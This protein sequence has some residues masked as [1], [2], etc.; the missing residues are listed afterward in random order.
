MQPDPSAAPPPATITQP[1]RKRFKFPQMHPCIRC[2][3]PCRLPLC[4][5]CRLVA[6]PHPCPRCGTTTKRPV[7][8]SMCTP[9]NIKLVSPQPPD[10]LPA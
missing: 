9:L 8:C 5:R 2:A 3:E 4:R 10:S 6:K 1:K 7:C